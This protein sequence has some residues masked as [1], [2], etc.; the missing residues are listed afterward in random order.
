MERQIERE[1]KSVP[2]TV[3][4]IP[5][6][7]SLVIM[8][9]F[10]IIAWSMYNVSRIITWIIIATKRFLW[11]LVRVLRRLLHTETKQINHFKRSTV[12]WWDASSTHRK[13][14]NIVN[15]MSRANSDKLN[16]TISSVRVRSAISN[17]IWYSSERCKQKSWNDYRLLDWPKLISKSG[18]P[19]LHLHFRRRTI[20]WGVES[21]RGR[22]KAWS[23]SIH[24]DIADVLYLVSLPTHLPSC[25]AFP[26]ILYGRLI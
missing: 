21:F 7:L 20:Y 11:I 4:S 23:L 1:W 10:R 16:P 3:F 12:T 17:F 24:S 22:S 6:W 2:H 5:E 25:S 18:S 13:L 9:R 14:Q 15:D 8:W 19:L 26:R